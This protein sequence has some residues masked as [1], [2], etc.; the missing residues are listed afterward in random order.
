M[1]QD[2]NQAVRKYNTDIAL[3]P[4]NI[5]ASMFGF[6]RDDA[7]FK[8]EGEAPYAPKVKF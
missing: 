7:Y 1:R 8:A 4:S 6:Y 5:A 2:Y 3:F